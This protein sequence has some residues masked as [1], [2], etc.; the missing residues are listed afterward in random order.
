MEILDRIIGEIK[1]A[2][3]YCKTRSKNKYYG[4]RFEE[5]VV[6]NSNIQKIHPGKGGNH[7]GNCLNGVATNTL[8]ATAP[9]HHPL[10]TCCWN[11][12]PIKTGLSTIWRDHRHRMQMEK[13]RGRLFPETGGH[14]EI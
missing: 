3:K 10:Q 4:D 13:Q 5:W 6:R 11:A 1:D 14:R 8:T 2:F 9:C 12:C 7:S